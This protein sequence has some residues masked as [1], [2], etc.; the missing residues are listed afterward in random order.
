MLLIS[1]LSAAASDS[2]MNNIAKDLHFNPVEIQHADGLQYSRNAYFLKMDKH[3]NLWIGSNAGL[4][5][6]DGISAKNY[7]NLINRDSVIIKRDFITDLKLDPEGDIW[8][9]TTEGLYKID[10]NTRTCKKIKYPKDVDLFYVRAIAFDGPEVFIGTYNGVYVYNQLEQKYVEKYLTDG[11]PS[12]SSGTTTKVW[13][14]YSDPISNELWVSTRNGLQ[15]IYR[16]TGK[17][18]QYTVPIPWAASAHYLL[19]GYATADKF[20]IASYHDGLVEFDR[21]SR[22]FT[23]TNSGFESQG[24]HLN[25]FKTV[26]PLSDNLSLA[27]AEYIGL[28]LYNSENKK[29]QWLEYD[30]LIQRGDYNVQLGNHGFVWF[31][32]EGKLFR[33]SKSIAQ[34]EQKENSEIELKLSR[35]VAN[36]QYQFIEDL[37]NQDHLSFMEDDKALEFIFGIPYNDKSEQIIFEYALDGGTW[38]KFRE[39]I[40]LF[41]LKGANHLL[42]VRALNREAKLISKKEITWDIHIPFFKRWYVLLLIFSLILISLIAIRYFLLKKD[43]EKKK[44]A[45]HYERKLHEL[46]SQALRSQ[47]NPHFIF[48]TLNSIKYYSIAKTPEETSDFI[49]DFSLLIRQILENSKENLIPLSDEIETLESYIRI[50]NMRFKRHFEY[51]IVKDSALAE[52]NFLVPPMIIQPFV[53]NAI[54]HGLMHK[55]DERKLYLFF[56]KTNVGICC[57]VRDNG[58]GRAAS[59]LQQHNSSH[60][61]SLGMKITQERLEILNGSLGMNNRFEII[62]L[63][64]DKGKA[65]GTEV[66][67]YFETKR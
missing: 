14:I 7:T 65:E 61:S 24:E 36:G 16:N 1:A 45:M 35:V 62:D 52:M 11:K 66:K 32:T 30:D 39:I 54:W 20:V 13:F 49:S 22:T 40:R 42:E 28:A 47:I 51:S 56:E 34:V 29:I 21:V 60:K 17:V 64:D 2:L 37:E 23:Q 67:I 25:R 6:Y 43:R 26:I 53:E 12:P 44:M 58:V 41:N 4:F 55:D 48:N 15:C 19:E 31:F 46:E 59:K 27:N 3:D 57:T 9:G 63:L 33:S 50:E 18:T 10:V 38:T 5:F 8:F